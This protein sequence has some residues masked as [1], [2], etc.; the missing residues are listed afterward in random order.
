MNNMGRL[1]HHSSHKVGACP[2]QKGAALKKK[3]VESSLQKSITIHGE[4]L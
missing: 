2:A 4:E 1:K 3:H